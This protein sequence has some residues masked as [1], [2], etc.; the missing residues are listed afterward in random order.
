MVDFKTRN[1]IW[2]RFLL[3]LFRRYENLYSKVK[4][5]TRLYFIYNTYIISKSVTMKF[6]GQQI[7]WFFVILLAICITNAVSTDLYSK[8]IYLLMFYLNL[9]LFYVNV[10]LND[11]YLPFF[12][13]N[14]S[15]T[16]ILIKILITHQNMYLTKYNLPSWNKIDAIAMDIIII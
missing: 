7:C 8:W 11:A 15:Q 12:L 16:K 6:F 14:R 3:S 5:H 1:V 9:F 13:L 2:T 10:N 4:Q